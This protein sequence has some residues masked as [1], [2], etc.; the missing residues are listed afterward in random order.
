MK[1]RGYA[2][3]TAGS[4]L[5]S[6]E[7]ERRDLGAHDVALDINTQEFVTAIFTRLPKNGDQQSF[8]WS[9]AMKS[10]A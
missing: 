5:V 3:L 2:A 10:R 1:S 8:P 6:H 9:L 4:T 7:F